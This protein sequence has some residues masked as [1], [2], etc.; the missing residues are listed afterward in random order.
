M[1]AIQLRKKPMQ[2][3]CRLSFLV[4]LLGLVMLPAGRAQASPERAFEHVVSVLPVW[5]GQQQ[6]GTGAPPG[7]APEGS[8]VVVRPD[9]IATAFHVVEPAERIDVRLSDGRIVPARLVAGDEA[10]DIALLK[11]E[12]GLTPIE[13]GPVP[14]LAEPV[15]AIGNTF[16]L[17]LSVTCG[18]VSAT[19]V[20]NAGF[21]AVED[22]IQTDAAI[23]PGTSGGALINRDGQLIGLV[24]AIFASDADANIGVNFAVSNDL[25]MRVV[26][27]LSEKGN[28]DY[29]TAGWRLGPAGRAQLATL[30]APQVRF[31]EPGGAAARAGVEPGDQ[32]VQIGERRT[33][34]PRDAITALALLPAETRSVP[35]V[36]QRAGVRSTVSLSFAAEAEE[37]AVSS[38]ASDPECPYPEAVC[39]QRQAVFPIS[40]YDPAASATRIAEDLLVTNRHVLGDR[41]EA[42]V[43]TPSGPRTAQVVPSAYEGDLVLLKTEGLPAEGAVLELDGAGPEADLFYAVGAD[44]ARREIRVFEPG[45]LIMLPADG[46][47][48]GR[49]HVGAHMQPGVSGGA[50]VG[51]NGRLRGIAVGGGDNRFEAIPVS[52]VED[53]LRRRDDPDADRM[54]RRLGVNFAACATA[55]ESAASSQNPAEQTDPLSRACARSTNHGQL[56][57]AGRVLA[58]AGAFDAAAD[59]HAQAVEQVPNSI[60]SRLSLLV[61]LQL[62]ARFE[63]MTEHARWLMEA[64]PQDPQALRFSI[65]SGVWGGDP[66][67]AEEGYRALLKAD[68]RQA[69]AARRFIDAAPPRPERR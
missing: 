35:L 62:G 56:L 20:T 34:T 6:G 57:E 13:F 64:A 54:T 24:S 55:I 69:Q 8:G 2:L 36:L 44:I 68:P 26:D 3:I 23:N 45:K 46:A 67:L 25:L 31:V 1:N 33:Q 41:L 7:T 18:V 39:R 17:G 61:S 15:C 47:K 53:L 60:N 22:F 40:A 50:L 12:A 49:L 16:G 28:V 66:E 38:G 63:D 43:H 42:T 21:N 11:V 27:A 14:G 48:L 30:A 4:V 52:A 10:S 19:A 9:M 59:L 51:E 58:R 29:L 5:P 65:Q 37:D 32:I